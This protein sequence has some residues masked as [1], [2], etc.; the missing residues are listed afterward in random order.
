[1]KTVI[2]TRNQKH[3]NHLE[4]F[5]AGR[6]IMIGWLALANFFFIPKLAANPLSGMVK[7]DT[8]LYS[9]NSVADANVVVF[10]VAYSNAVDGDDATKMSNAGENIAIQRGSSLLVV[11]GRQ[12]A[13]VNDVVPFKIWNLR[14]QSYRLD[15]VA[16]N[17]LTP[18][19]VAVLE[20]AYLN[21]STAINPNGTTSINFTVN[22]NAGSFAVNR[23]R[24][25]FKPAA[26]LPVTFTGISANRI[27]AGVKIDWKVTDEI[28]IRSYEIQRS[29]DGRN[30]NAAGT[31]KAAG[32]SSV[33]QR[34]SFNDVLAA[35]GLIYYRIKTLELNG[36]SKYSSIVKV[37]AAGAEKGFAIVANPVENGIVNLQLK[38]QPAGRYMVRLINSTGQCCFTNTVNH[39]GGSS[40]VLFNLTGS[41]ASGVYRLMVVDPLNTITSQ[42]LVISR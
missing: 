14:Q 11:E 32:N 4:I 18:G 8:R 33:E 34:Y 35:A 6:Y 37:N 25:I 30:F 36:D 16:A 24:I 31:V 2:S 27:S 28:N 20:D 39:T 41:M 13:F 29:L 3:G 19:L 40:N 26:A 15:V 23:F 7:I 17:L 12:P 5:C 1:M 42:T 9:N 21:T 10:D 22:S 38:N